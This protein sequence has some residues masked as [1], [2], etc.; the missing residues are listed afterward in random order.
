MA[1]ATTKTPEESVK[2]ALWQYTG[3]TIL[4]V[5]TFL[6]GV[7][8]AWLM[9]GDAPGLRKQVED[10]TKSV[11]A[12][13]VEREDAQVKLGRAERATEKL[14]AQYDQLKSGAPPQ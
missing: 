1:E 6:A 4:L 2:E 9:W 7:A 13:R 8:V 12:A 3:W 11:A 10:L 14:Q 5:L